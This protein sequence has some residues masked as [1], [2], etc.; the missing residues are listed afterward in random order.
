MV[1][2]R[3]PDGKPRR[4][5]GTHSDITG[6][7]RDITASRKLENELKRQRAFLKSMMDAI[8]DLIFYKD[9]N[10]VYLGC[11]SAFA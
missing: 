11:N 7:A 10:S 5:I 6:I 8:P 3:L 4:I 1:I 9:I 2:E